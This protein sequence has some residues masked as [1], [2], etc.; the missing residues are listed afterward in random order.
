MFK[1]RLGKFLYNLTPLA[2]LISAACSSEFKTHVELKLQELCKT[3]NLPTATLV[4]NLK[5]GEQVV[6]GRNPFGTDNIA[7]I[8]GNGKFT[9]ENPKIPPTIENGEITVINKQPR[10]LQDY[11]NSISMHVLPN[12]PDIA[13]KDNPNTTIS[14]SMNCPKK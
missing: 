11:D 14:F 8:E 5:K 3:N 2:L 9:I 7:T 4:M 10:S 12:D 6:V 13:I 1:E